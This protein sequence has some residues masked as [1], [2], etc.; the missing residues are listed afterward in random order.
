MPL[1][2][3]VNVVALAVGASVVSAHGIEQNGVALTPNHF[4]CNPPWALT[5]TAVT[6][7]QV[8]VRNDDPQDA[9]TSLRSAS[10]S[11]KPCCNRGSCKSAIES[12]CIDCYRQDSGAN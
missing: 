8:T 7:T 11:S 5:V 10:F 4:V 2:A 12:T 6:G 9:Y 1:I 3:D